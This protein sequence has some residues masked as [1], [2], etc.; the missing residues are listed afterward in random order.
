MAFPSDSTTLSVRSLAPDEAAEATGT[1]CLASCFDRF[2]RVVGPS[3]ADI[4][5]VPRNSSVRA[6]ALDRRL[7][8]ESSEVPES[9]TELEVFKLAVTCARCL[10]EILLGLEREAAFRF[11]ESV[12]ID[13][14]LALLRARVLAADPSSKGIN[15]ESRIVEVGA[16]SEHTIHV[17][18]V[19]D[20]PSPVLR[21]HICASVDNKDTQLC[22]R[23]WWVRIIRRWRIGETLRPVQIV[24]GV[25][26][27]WIL[28]AAW[29]L[30]IAW[31]VVKVDG[32]VAVESSCAACGSR[33]CRTCA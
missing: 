17:G 14:D 21:V 18:I 24:V 4:V 20:W 5:N 29:R 26:E 12:A 19:R 10:V 28:V 9:L 32:E 1:S 25:L 8:L 3:K 27:R 22:T 31:Q 30:P 13:L 33:G 7:N 2:A 16:C 15:V 6:V 23:V 11:V